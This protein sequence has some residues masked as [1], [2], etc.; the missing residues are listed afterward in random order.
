MENFIIS[1]KSC[2]IRS[3]LYNTNKTQER[4]RGKI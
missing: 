2:S 4:R 3:Y 1:D